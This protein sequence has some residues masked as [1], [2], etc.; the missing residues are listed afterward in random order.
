MMPSSNNKL[1]TLKSFQLS[2]LRFS[3][4]KCWLFPLI[5]I[6]TARGAQKTASQVR[7]TFWQMIHI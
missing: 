4:G 6:I 2:H 7:W 5:A 1:S 3:D